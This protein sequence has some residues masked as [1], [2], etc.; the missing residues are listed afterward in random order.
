MYVTSFWRSSS[1]TL[2][3]AS[4]CRHA[5]PLCAAASKQTELP[6]PP[7]QKLVP[8]PHPCTIQVDELLKE[9]SVKNTRGSGP[10]GQHR[11]KV[12]TAVVI[13]H[14]PTDVVG[15]AS[16][17][18]SQKTNLNNAITRLRVKLALSC[19][20]QTQVQQD[21]SLVVQAEPNAPAEL[22]APSKLWK[23]R[24]KGGKIAISDT[25]VDFPPVLCE[26]LDCIW[27]VQDVKAASEGLG[28]STSQMV[29]LLA[30]EPAA[31]QLVNRLRAS[32]GQPPLRS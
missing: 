16:E 8:P 25:H 23:S 15:Q 1:S 24:V 18:R 11:N 31:L 7:S 26:A 14:L 12:A 32:E 30:K 2:L 9:C 5:A 22:K 13:N 17:S 20:T 27:S 3:V 10:G 4:L 29:K 6:K 19:R 28:I 21:D